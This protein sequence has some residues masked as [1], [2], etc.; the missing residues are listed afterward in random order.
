MK[1]RADF[2]RMF[3]QGEKLSIVTDLIVC[4]HVNQHFIGKGSLLW[5][6]TWSIYFGK[7]VFFWLKIHRFF[8]QK[9]GNFTTVATFLHFFSQTCLN[10][11]FY[12]HPIVFVHLLIYRFSFSGINC[13]I[14]S[15]IL[16][17]KVVYM[18]QKHC[19][20]FRKR[21]GKIVVKPC[22]KEGTKGNLRTSRGTYI[23]S[24]IKWQILAIS[25]KIIGNAS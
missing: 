14:S 10:I 25:L 3:D 19:M 11:N 1:S 13:R 21:W 8:L 12:S 24:W 7:G 20:F 9:D 4:T 17:K 22:G 5:P 23:W 6:W 16:K 2:S 18:S 15:W